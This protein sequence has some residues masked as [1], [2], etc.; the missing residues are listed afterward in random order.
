LAGITGVLVGK[1]FWNFGCS[2]IDC[3]TGTSTGRLDCLQLGFNRPCLETPLTIAA[4]DWTTG[5]QSRI[6][7][8]KRYGAGTWHRPSSVRPAPGMHIRSHP[9]HG[10][11]AVSGSSSLSQI[12]SL[13]TNRGL[14]PD[15]SSHT[16]PVFS[17]IHGCSSLIESSASAASGFPSLPQTHLPVTEVQRPAHP[18][19]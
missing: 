16:C 13:A 7:L 4:F 12:C 14:D 2:I 18:V 15:A 3:Y 8:A 17:S 6:S 9:T 19:S 1:A 10:F 5:L 11:Q